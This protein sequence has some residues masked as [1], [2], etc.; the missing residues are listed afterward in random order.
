MISIAEARPPYVVF[1]YQAQENRTES[2]TSGH[3]VSK[4]VAMAIITPQGSKDRIV[5]NAEE[6]L[7]HITQE[8]HNGRFPDTWVS[9]F[10][11][12]FAA[13]VKDEQI[14][15]DGTS[16]MNWP[17]AS[18]AQVKSLKSAGIRTVEDLAVANEESLSRIGMGA[19][20]LKALAANWLSSASSTGQTA[21]RLSSLEQVNKELMAANAALLEQ[22]K[23]LSP[24]ATSVKL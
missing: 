24:P 11:A 13:W 1:E 6:W 23:K 15:E 2:I 22:L 4:D 17:A 8:S 12:R 21:A 20:A 5:R 18:P 14:P 9:A 19:R 3:Y 16:V 10:R 7:D